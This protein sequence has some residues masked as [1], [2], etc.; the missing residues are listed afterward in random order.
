[1]KNVYKLSA[2]EPQGKNH[3][4]DLDVDAVIILKLILKNYGFKNTDWN[5]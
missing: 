5:I 1:M 2:G 3:L 4:G